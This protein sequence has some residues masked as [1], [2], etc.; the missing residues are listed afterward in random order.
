LAETADMS[1]EQITGEGLDLHVSNIGGIDDTEVSF[2]P[3]VTLLVGENATNRTSL[4]Q[5]VMAGLGSDRASIRADAEEGHVSMTVGDQ[6]YERTLRSRNGT[7]VGDGKEFLQDPTEAELFAFLLESNEARRAVAL[8]GDLRELIMQP[9]DTD[10]IQSEISRLEDEKREVETRLEE[11]EQLKEQ[12]PQLETER[13]D[14]EREI[15]QLRA[16]LRRKEEKIEA[17]DADFE[18]SRAE[19]ADLEETLEDLRR[20]RSELES[21]RYKLDTRRESLRELN[22]ERA[23]LATERADLPEVSKDRLDSIE[24]ELKGLRDRRSA[25]ERELSRLQSLVQFNEEMLEGNGDDILVEFDETEESVT[26]QLLGNERVCWTC[27]TKVNAAQIESTVDR[28][29]DLRQERIQESNE[30]DEQLERLESERD[31]LHEQQRRRELLEQ[32]LNDI[33]NRIQNNETCIADLETRRDELSEEVT[34]LEKEAERTEQDDYS[35][36][37]ELHKEANELEFELKRR[38][39]E[40][41]EVNERIADI[42]T[43]LKR[44][45]DLE[46]ELASIDAELDERR[47]RIERIEQNAIEA[48]NEHM[49]TVLELLGYA[50]LERIWLERTE[51]EVREGRR[52]V[53]RSSF[54]LHVI[55]STASGTVYEDTVDH[56]SESE[57]EVTGLVFAL[58]G[59]LA[60][61]VHRDVPVMLLDSVEAIDSDRI[62]A[63]VGYLE[64]Y[65]AYL[66]IA[67]LPGDAAALDESYRRVIEI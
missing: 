7:V 58:A 45:G 65:T 42:E 15:D 59:Y 52:V 26:D 36:I 41:D 57:R 19:Q 44:E 67:L 16:A 11:L 53:T 12:L 66:I 38:K 2:A 55:R 1:T 46:R 56:L 4:L 34:A 30:V 27:G 18:E 21:V 5:A 29:R 3:G 51:R 17:A 23:S 43:E 10:A 24:T 54:D 22:Q 8:D 39:E 25:V 13:Q 64:E 49:E 28:L 37:I 60:H 31:E 40:L 62:A 47:T 48:F 63:L 35:E 6:T 61:E 14:L 9:I 33:D 50:N 32:R 20:T